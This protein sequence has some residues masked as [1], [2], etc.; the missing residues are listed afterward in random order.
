MLRRIVQ[1][2]DLI[3]GLVGSLLDSG[4]GGGGGGGGSSSTSSR[5]M[6][7]AGIVFDVMSPTDG[8]VHWRVGWISTDVN[9]NGCC[10]M[11]GT[12]TEDLTTLEEESESLGTSGFDPVDEDINK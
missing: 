8:V 4:G 1:A 3:R 6:W 2:S 9:S 10:C 11:V 7:T 5:S 12:S